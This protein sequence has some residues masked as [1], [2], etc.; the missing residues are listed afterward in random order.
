MDGCEGIS[1]R[2]WD[3][4]NQNPEGGVADG[5]PGEDGDCTGL[6]EGDIGDGYPASGE[7]T[8]GD[9]D[10]D[11]VGDEIG[12]PPGDTLGDLTATDSPYRDVGDKGG[13]RT[14]ENEP[15]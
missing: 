3:E 2:K 9:N 10:G 1:E 14:G 5:D 13:D 12:E 8:F 11:D 15:A 7:N 6:R 4:E